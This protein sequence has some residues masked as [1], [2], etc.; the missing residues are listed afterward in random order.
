MAG[1]AL[2]AVASHA[3]RVDRTKSRKLLL[4]KNFEK[5]KKANTLAGLKFIKISQ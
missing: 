4:K 3:F 1:L 5:L 2:I